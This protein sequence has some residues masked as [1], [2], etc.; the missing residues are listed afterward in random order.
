[1]YFNQYDLIKKKN[2]Y[3]LIESILINSKEFLV[4]VSIYCGIL[5]SKNF[6]IKLYIS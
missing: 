4:H 2:T 6:F 3:D 1:M 5:G